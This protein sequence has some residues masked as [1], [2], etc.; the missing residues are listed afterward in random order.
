MP[1]TVV[2]IANGDLRLSANQR[3]WPA[4][5]KVE[6]AVMNA[7]RREGRE[8]RRGHQCDPG[9][10]SR[11]YRQPE[12]RDGGVPG[13]SSAG[14]AGGGGGRLAVQPSPAA[15]TLHAPGAH[16]DGRQLERGVAGAG[17][18][19]E[20][21]RL[22]DQGRGS[23]QL[24]VERG[25]HGRSVSAGPAPLAGGRNGGS[26]PE[27]CPAV[28]RVSACRQQAEQLG[29]RLA[30]ELRRNKAI[31]G[32]FDEGCMGMY[33]AIIPDELLHPTGVFKERLSQ[34]ALYA[35]MRQVSDAESARCAAVAGRQRHAVRH[36]PESR[37]RSHRRADSGSMPHV[38]GG[39]PHRRRFRLRH[40]RHPVSAGTE[41]PGSGIRPGRGTAEQR[42]PA[43]GDGARERASAL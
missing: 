41:G 26:R 22:A 21:E 20:S 33:N 27:P 16:P 25:F 19:A 29:A 28:E 42:R 1:E 43:A 10:G 11:L 2:L 4:Q 3:C 35:E 5:A 30:G 14:A 36:R 6:E 24:P 23:L 8:V 32:I 37:D 34:S 7:I 9:K 15:R 31:M 18:H 40:D 17:G 13:D 38:R 39:A 12:A